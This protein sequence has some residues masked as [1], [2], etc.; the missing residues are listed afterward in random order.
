MFPFWVGLSLHVFFPQTAKLIE[1][2]L[3]PEGIFHPGVSSFPKRI[4]SKLQ[5]AFIVRGPPA[6]DVKQPVCCHLANWA[7][8]PA[9][10]KKNLSHWVMTRLGA[11]ACQ[12]VSHYKRKP[13]NMKP[14]TNKERRFPACAKRQKGFKKKRLRR[15]SALPRVGLPPSQATAPRVRAL[16]FS[17]D[18]TGNLSLSGGL[19]PRGASPSVVTPGPP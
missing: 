1:R 9:R 11:K 16:P 2:I 14:H 15:P 12:T 4:D 18:R 10:T 8:Y 6:I 13:K 7:A 5:R 17:A 3:P 19:G